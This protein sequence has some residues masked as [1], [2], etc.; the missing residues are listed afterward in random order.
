ML[1]VIIPT[2][3]H[4]GYLE[5]LIS[6]VLF[7]AGSPVT[8][9][10]ICND[11]STDETAAILAKY[12]GDDRIRVFHNPQSIGATASVLMMYTHVRTPYV[13]FMASDDYFYPEKL[14]KLFDGMLSQDAFVGFGKYVIEDGSQIVELQHPG[15]KA[16]GQN[17]GDEFCSI[18]GFDHY[19]SF[20]VTIF[21]CDR[22]PRY[23]RQNAPW[24]VSLDHTVESDGLGDFRAH[25]WNLAL[26]MAREYPDRFYFLD[27][28]C[29]AFRK[30]GSQLSSDEKY[31]HTGRAAYEM[32]VLILKFLQ[33]YEV[34]KRIKGSEFARNA[35][36]SLFYLK[37]GQATAEGMQSRNFVE[38]YK[39]VLLAA[40]T[41]LSN[42]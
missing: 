42:M 9:L 3:N 19:T 25:D 29:G 22:L 23:G 18:L 38:I 31:L 37:V 2:K 6:N 16:R 41:L 8:E 13:M 39:P 5:H 36:K 14:A 21:K 24:D 10:L 28:Y 12:A 4:C 32:A 7:A 33:N 1:S 27:E 20:I 26:D 40:D 17:G 34:R 15:W 30:V 35:V 11:G